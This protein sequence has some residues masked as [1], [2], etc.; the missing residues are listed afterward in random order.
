HRPSLRPSPQP[1]PHA[2][3][4]R[5][6]CH[7]CA[8]RRAHRRGRL[9][10][11]VMAGWSG[12]MLAGVPVA[13]L[14]SDGFGWRAGFLPAAVLALLAV[15]LIR[16][17]CPPSPAAAIP[18]FDVREGASFLRRMAMPLA[19]NFLNMLSFY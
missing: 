18:R 17:P 5:A 2:G 11:R 4:A 13:G 6:A 12:A 3:R 10:G 7:S 14:L 19:V 9:M 15:L 1:D 8:Q 16:S